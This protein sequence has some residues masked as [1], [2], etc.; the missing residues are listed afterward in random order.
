MNLSRDDQPSRPA[1]AAAAELAQL[2][3]EDL[4][5]QVQRGNR[6]AFDELV[7]RYKG[8]LYSFILRMV[9]EPD[10]AEENGSAGDGRPAP[11][12]CGNG[13]QGLC[14]DDLEVLRPGVGDPVE[15]P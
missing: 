13:L 12:P 9:K 4:I 7:A 11:D 15:F 3:D 8:R 10:L 14:I 6:R 2:R 1:N 5:V